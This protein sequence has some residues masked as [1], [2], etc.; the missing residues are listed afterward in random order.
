MVRVVVP[1]RAGRAKSRL[2]LGSG[3]AA[4]MLEDVLDAASAVGEA[5]VAAAEGGQGAAVAAQLE[6]MSDGPVLV[7]N[8]DL[9]RATPRD[10][11]ALLGSVP[12]GGMALVE[13]PDGTTNALALA[14]PRQF[15]DLYGAGSADRFR[16]HARALGVECV[17]ADI[18][19]LAADVDTRADL[20]GDGFGRHTREALAALAA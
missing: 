9:P 14:S 10:L 11:L 18:P 2:G 12:P 16:R 4:A 7:V 17:T 13:A 6:R 19:N 20:S 3:I 8:A 5:I 1:F 15:A